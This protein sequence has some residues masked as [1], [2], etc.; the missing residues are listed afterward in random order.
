MAEKNGPKN[1][2]QSSWMRS[3]A[4]QCKQAPKQQ[5]SVKGRQ[6]QGTCRKPKELPN[7]VPSLPE[8]Q[9]RAH[10]FPQH[11]WL[12]AMAAVLR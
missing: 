7:R 6:R 11:R 9:N 1:T 2:T 12:P 10:L 5:S 3:R 4:I 8:E